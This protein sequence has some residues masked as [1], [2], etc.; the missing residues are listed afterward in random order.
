MLFKSPDPLEH[1]VCT[2]TT[3]TFNVGVNA[4]TAL[5]SSIFQK[6]KP[7]HENKKSYLSLKAL[8]SNHP[9][10]PGTASEQRRKEELHPGRDCESY[11]HRRSKVPRLVRLHPHVL[12]GSTADH[13]QHSSALLNLGS[14]HFCGNCSNDSSHS[15]ERLHCQENAF[16]QRMFFLHVVLRC[17]PSVINK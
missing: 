2:F 3:R 16:F 9:T 13:H 5:T 14:F 12:V 10:L 17:Y 8:H 7:S 6:V 11:V 1:H 15:H 4:R